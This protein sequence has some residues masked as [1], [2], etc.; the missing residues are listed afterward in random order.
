MLS[1]FVI[2]QALKSLDKNDISE[3]KVFSKP[4]ELVQIVMEG[5][6]LLLGSKYVQASVIYVKLTRIKLQ[7]I[8]N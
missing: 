6:C 2:L 5:V 3:L 8:S 1:F 4:P 7:Y